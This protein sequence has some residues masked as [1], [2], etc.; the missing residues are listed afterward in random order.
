MFNYIL[1]FFLA[2]MFEIVRIKGVID[3]IKIVIDKTTLE[4]YKEFYFEQYPKRKKFPLKKTIPPSINEWIYAKNFMVSKM[5]KDWKEFIVWLMDDLGY[6]NLKIEKCREYLNLYFDST[7]RHD[8]DNYVPKFI[9][10]GLTE[11]GVIMD[12]D[13]NCVNTLIVN[14]N[15][16]IENPRTEVILEI[17][18]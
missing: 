11:A 17:I 18:K 7:R 1:S 10:D 8:S 15:I 2:F 13:F 14:G 6:T 16:D 12:D 3:M 9:N 4:R 5:K